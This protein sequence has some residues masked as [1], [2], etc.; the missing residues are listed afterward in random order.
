MNSVAE[1]QFALTRHL[2]DPEQ[3]PAP[4]G[5]E[6]RRLKVYQE[7]VFNNIEGFLSS[8]FP[9]MHSLLNEAEWLALVRAFVREYRAQSPYFLEIGQEFYQFVSQAEHLALPEFTLELMHYE[10]VELALDV[11]PDQLPP[12]VDGVVAEATRLQRS[13]LAWPLAYRFPVHRIGPD[14][15]PTAAPEAPSLFVVHRDRQQQVRF[16]AL[17]SMSY[18][19]LLRFD[20]VEQWTLADLAAAFAAQMPEPPS[21]QFVEQLRVTLQHFVDQD[22]LLICV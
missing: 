22:I 17:N 16:M 14:Y 6:M 8:G 1:Q 4:T 9:I 19:L 21:P 11:A 2:R 15:Q 20:E 10:W 13:P 7:L 3:I 5:V 18:A 12:A